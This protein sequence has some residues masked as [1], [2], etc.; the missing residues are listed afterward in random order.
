VAPS[1]PSAP[2]RVVLVTGGSSGIGRATAQRLADEG[3]ALVLVSRSPSTLE[4]TR[5]E[6]LE[7]GAHDVLT[8]TADVRLRPEVEAAFAAALGRFGRLDGV[9]H[10][11]AVIAY[12]RFSDLPADVFDHVVE[13]DILGTANVARCALAAFERDQAGALVVL[14]SVLGKMTAP[15]MSAYAA[16]KW[17]VHGMVRTL[18]VEARSLPGVH[19]SLV[20]PG[21]V[22]TPIYQLAGSFTGRVGRPPPPVGSAEKAARVVVDALSRPRRDADVGPANIVMVLGFR[23][24]PG[25]FDLLV[26]P[27]MRVLGQGRVQRPA[28][29]GNVFEPTPDLEAVHGPWRWWGGRGG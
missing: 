4:Q 29:P 7:R 3:A 20:S 9:V 27:L 17:A 16:G 14:G 11:A 28:D 25:L 15:S 21:S 18:Q 5:R 2:S 12:G 24:V 22:N 19:V 23:L 26:G 6:C 1:S 8:V 13:T 10:A